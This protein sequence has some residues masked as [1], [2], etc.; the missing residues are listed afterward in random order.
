MMALKFSIYYLYVA[1]EFSFT[2]LK[3]L[4]KRDKSLLSRSAKEVVQMVAENDNIKQTKNKF[5]LLVT[6]FKLKNNL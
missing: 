5:D 3:I 2:D 6:D 4:F 1:F